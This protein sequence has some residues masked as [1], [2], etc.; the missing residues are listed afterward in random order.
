MTCPQ[1]TLKITNLHSIRPS[2]SYKLLL[3]ACTVHN[4]NDERPI[5][6]DVANLSKRKQNPCWPSEWWPGQ[7]GLGRKQ[8][9]ANFV[10]VQLYGYINSAT[11]V[12]NK[13]KM[14]FKKKFFLPYTVSITFSHKTNLHKWK[15]RHQKWSCEINRNKTIQHAR[16]LLSANFVPFLTKT[17]E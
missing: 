14:K 16:G 4:N 1:P 9:T 12:N 6:R 7:L 3:A 2:L 8:K 13:E 11:V 17:C 15:R 10:G 5:Y